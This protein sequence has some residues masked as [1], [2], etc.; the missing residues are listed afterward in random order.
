[1]IHPG[2][3]S[4]QGYDTESLEVDPEATMQDAR[5]VLGQ[6]G[7][8]PEDRGDIVSAMDLRQGNRFYHYSAPVPAEENPYDD[9]ELGEWG[10]TIHDVVND[11]NWYDGLQLTDVRAGPGDI[12]YE[13]ADDIDTWL[14][15]DYVRLFRDWLR[16]EVVEVRVETTYFRT[17]TGE[18]V[19]PWE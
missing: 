7:I 12:E 3:K 14:P 19:D 11:T 16:G 1:M 17:D 10:P 2:E 9:C 4:M 6:L 5:D 18:P 13:R 15:L 8:D